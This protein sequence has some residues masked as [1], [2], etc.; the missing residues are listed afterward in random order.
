MSQFI[1]GIITSILIGLF[2]I[3]INQFIDW[4]DITPYLTSI[5][6][7]VNYLFWFDTWIDI[8]T[9]FNL[10]RIVLLIEFILMTMRF[11]TRIM[12]FFTGSS[13]TLHD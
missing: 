8:T 6:T 5:Q 2:L 9:L 3:V 1:F 11:F 4:P 7:M 10:G 13:T 12:S